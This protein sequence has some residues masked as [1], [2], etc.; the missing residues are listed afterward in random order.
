[1]QSL[2]DA[3]AR[4]SSQL[5]RRQMLGINAGPGKREFF[6]TCLEEATPKLAF[7]VCDGL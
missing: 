1:M 3:H 4:Y 7:P 6:N 2:I 5:A